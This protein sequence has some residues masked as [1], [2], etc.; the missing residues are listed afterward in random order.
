MQFDFVKYCQCCLLDV[1]KKAPGGMQVMPKSSLVITDQRQVNLCF[2]ANAVILGFDC[3]AIARAKHFLR[4]QRVGEAGY[5]ALL[6][7]NQSPTHVS[8]LVIFKQIMKMLHVF[9][10]PADGL[11][12]AC[13]ACD[14]LN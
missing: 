11:H 8:S 9:A 10:P 5:N 1:D 3:P 4:M 14:L 13:L 6:L 2:C 7:V 12:F